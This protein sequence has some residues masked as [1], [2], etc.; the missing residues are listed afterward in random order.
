ME[1]H[2]A[3]SAKPPFESYESPALTAELQ[4]RKD[5]IIMA[6]REGQSNLVPRAV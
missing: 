1:K 2:D 4:A 6:Q 5:A 3:N